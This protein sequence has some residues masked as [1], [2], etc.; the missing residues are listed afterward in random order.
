MQAKLL[1]FLEQKEIQRLSREFARD[2]LFMNLY[3]SGAD[4]A[5]DVTSGTTLSATR[6]LASVGEGEVHG[7]TKLGFRLW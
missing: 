6:T 7:Q 5:L 1:R 3:G 2:V 4:G